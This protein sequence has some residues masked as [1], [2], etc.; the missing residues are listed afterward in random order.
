MADRKLYLLNYSHARKTRSNKVSYA[1]KSLY[2][3]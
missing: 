1:T 3:L 2:D